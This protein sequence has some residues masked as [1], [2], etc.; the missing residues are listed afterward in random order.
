M[1]HF[2]DLEALHRQM[3]AYP[4]VI[5]DDCITVDGTVVTVSFGKLGPMEEQAATLFSAYTEA[6]K[7]Q[8][9]NAINAAR[10]RFGLATGLSAAEI[11]ERAL[12]K[13]RQLASLAPHQV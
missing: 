9:T 6:L 13:E 1:T 12:E 4:R 11:H 5:P 3:E 8:D 7:T 2:S 10:K